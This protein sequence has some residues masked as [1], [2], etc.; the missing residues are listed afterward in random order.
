MN[1]KYTIILFIVFITLILFPL[2][3]FRESE[4]NK[5]GKIKG[6]KSAKAKKKQKA[7]KKKQQDNNKK[8]ALAGV[9]TGAGAIA[10][11]SE[12]ATQIDKC[13]VLLNQSG[14]NGLNGS[15]GANGI[16]GQSSIADS[17]AGTDSNYSYLN[18]IKSPKELNMSD[19]GTMETLKKD[20]KGLIA[21]VELLVQGSSSASKTKGPLGNKFFVK[22]LGKCKS[23]DN[24]NKGSIQD[25]YFYVNNVPLGN[26][27]FTSGAG[28]KDFR[29]LIPGMLQ[30][31][32]V[33][34]PGNVASAFLSSSNPDCMAV[35]LD[36]I[37]SKG[38]QGSATHYVTLTDIIDLDPCLFPKNAKKQ[39]VNPIT[40]AV[41]KEG[42]QSIN[43]F[44]NDTSSETSDT[45]DLIQENISKDYVAQLFLSS[46]GLFGIYILFMAMKKMK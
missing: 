10:I 37:D 39:R 45:P 26:I 5:G 15:N 30:N 27:P 43:D 11:S 4:K 32:D 36:T 33:I 1:P 9:G 6:V 44:D 19:K 13:K 12:N 34:N 8:I 20:I 38:I 18:F 24:T 16:N 2:F 35:T 29:G 40:N 23:I 31:M 22:T 17:A 25:R 3:T 28:Y 21:Y 42:F 46:I 7:K 14:V 41:C